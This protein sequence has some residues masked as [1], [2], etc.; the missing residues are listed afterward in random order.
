MQLVSE[1]LAVKVAIVLSFVLVVAQCNAQSVP[2]APESPAIAALATRL[3][4]SDANALPEFWATVQS[5]HTPLI[6][7]IPGDENHVLAT[8]LWHGDNTT[9]DVVLMAQPNG[10]EMLHDASSHLL[11]LPG[12]DVWYRTH[13]LPV[14]AEFSYLLSINPPSASQPSSTDALQSTL[15]A[16]P[17]N[18]LHYRILTG[19]VRSIAR[20][21]AVPEDPWLK[22]SDSASLELREYTIH[23]TVLAKEPDRKLWIYTTPGEIRHPNLLVLLDAEMYMKAVPAP[24]MLGS[25]YSAGKIGPTIAVFVDSGSDTWL[26]DHY[27]DDAYV[28]F[29][30]DEVVPW[31][32]SQYHFKAGHKHTI[33]GGESIEG[34]TAA[35]AALR[36]PDVFGGVISQSGSF[37]INNHDADN[38]EPEWL[39]RQFARGD[40]LDVFFCLDAGRMEFVRNDGDRIF[41]QFVPGVTNLLASTRH[42]RDVLVAKGY[43]LYYSETYGDHEPLRWSRTLP[44]LLVAAMASH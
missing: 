1:V 27:F 41:P 19:P 35:F 5:R 29:L 25:L 21:P 37:W 4:G 2:P 44:E 6:E 18:P 7:K 23:S 14:D 42:L 12:T 40:R 43:R 26:S 20:M 28:R 11:R 36:R 39:A 16:D 8:F 38:G 17:L 34:M 15:V 13:R 10:V 31:V 9:K 24:L 22:R 3:A 33:I 30:A 32:E